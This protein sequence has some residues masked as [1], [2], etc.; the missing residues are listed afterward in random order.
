MNGIEWTLGVTAVVLPTIA[1]LS[2]NSLSELTLYSIFPPLGII[3]FGLMW[4]HFVMGALRRYSGSTSSPHWLYMNIS[5]GL[6]LSLIVLHPGLLWVALY[7]DGFGLPPQSHLE[8]YSTQILFVTL[9][10]IGLLI[11][12][13]YEFKRFFGQRSWWKY[14]EWLQ[15][16]GM[17][18]I[19]VHAIGLGGELQLSWFMVVW[20]FYGLTLAASFVYSRFIYKKGSI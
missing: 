13:S 8:A 17:G 16:L 14:I 5:M 7:L 10:T 2:R 3:A 4:T 12:L 18:A 15:I 19:F 1:W 11:F 9:G 6:V 20:I